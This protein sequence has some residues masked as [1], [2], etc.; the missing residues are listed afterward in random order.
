MKN[1]IIYLSENPLSYYPSKSYAFL[2]KGIK[3][4]TK[5]S[6]RYVFKYDD[7]L[8]MNL[9]LFKKLAWRNLARGC[10]CDY[11][12]CGHWFT[13]HMNIKRKSS[14][15]FEVEAFNAQNY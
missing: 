14:T 13:T 15:K 4:S 8:K 2:S 12:C 3:G 5:F 7:D 9:K 10:D 11:D 6:N 1:S